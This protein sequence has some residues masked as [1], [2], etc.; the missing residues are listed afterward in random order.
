MQLL[1]ELSSKVWAL[2]AL[3]FGLWLIPMGY[4]A[5]TSRR[6]PIALGWA[7]MIGGVG[8]VL[9][10]FLS[11]GVAHAPSWITNGLTLPATVS[12][13][14]MIAFSLLLGCKRP[15][16]GRLQMTVAAC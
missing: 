8:Y 11:N 10:T 6:M 7:L 9:S 12:E 13:F 2:A 4:V 15:T 14:W 5:A 3:F 16:L 1:Y